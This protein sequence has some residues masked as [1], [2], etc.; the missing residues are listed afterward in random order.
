MTSLLRIPKDVVWNGVARAVS[1]G[2]QLLRRR[3][4]PRSAA[5]WRAAHFSYAHLGEDLIVLTLLADRV[6]NPSKG[7]YVDVGA[8]DP[9][10]YSN[11]L[12]LHQHG[13]RGINIDG[14]AERI[15]RF[16]QERP[17]DVNVCAL[18][19]DARRE[20]QYVHYPTGGLDQ[21]IGVEDRPRPNIAGELPTRI[22]RGT[23]HTLTE[24]LGEYLSPGIEIDFLNVDCEGQDLQVLRG[25]DW[26]RWHPRVVAVE[27]NTP[28]ERDE[29]TAFLSTRGYTLE[30]RMRVT[31]I[32]ARTV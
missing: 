17:R 1:T 3:P 22:D 26:D 16:R 13:W 28:N 2:A 18:V 10:W 30:A 23:T 9:V 5:E 4:G 29:L 6:R 11:T 8:F 21:V 24:L 20:V 32:F 12:L 27:G 7:V 19:S 15:N 31:L 25:H 14:D